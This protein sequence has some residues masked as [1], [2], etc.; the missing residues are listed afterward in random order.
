MDPS[1]KIFFSEMGKDNLNK[2]P[3]FIIFI[4]KKKKKNL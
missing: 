3:L 4:L 1:D 2:M